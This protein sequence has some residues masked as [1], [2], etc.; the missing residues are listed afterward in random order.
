MTMNDCLIYPGSR[1]TGPRSGARG[2]LRRRGAAA[3]LVDGAVLA[4]AL[5]ACSSDAQ[6]PG[7]SATGAAGGS[8]GGT[9]GS[10]ATGGGAGGSGGATAGSNA[11][12]GGAGGSGATG[13][14]AG[15]S[16]AGAGGSGGSGGADGAVYTNP[17]IPG[18]FADPSVIRVGNDYWATATSSEWGAPFPLLHSTD[19]VNW[20]RV[21][22]VF[23]E[24]PSWAS[25]SLWAPEISEDGG[26]YQVFYT[27][28]QRG[29]PLCVAAASAEAPEGPYTDHG[30]LTCMEVG[31][32][33]GFPIRD[34]DGVRHLVW[35]E[36][37]NSVGAPTP[38]WAQELSEDGTE[39]LGAPVALFQNE[40]SWEANL[41]E[42]PYLMRHGGY[43]YAFYSGAGCCG[44]SCSYSLGVARAPGLLGP[45]EKNPANP[46]LAGN[47][48]WKCPG[49]G[50]VVDDGGGRF[51]LLYHAYSV[52]DSVYVGRQGLLDEAIFGADGWPTI[53]GGAG[54]SATAEAPIAPQAP[55]PAE[56][57]DEFDGDALDPHWQW[58]AAAPPGAALDPADGGWLTLQAAPEAP[59][60]QLG[61][62]IGRPTL[63]GDYEVTTELAVEPDVQAGL[64]A[65]GDGAS[66]VGISVGGGLAAVFRLANSTS[67][68]VA[69]TSTPG[70]AQLRM[71]VANG[72]LFRFAI[73]ADGAADWAPLGGIVDS[74]AGPDLPPWDRGVRAALF[75]NGPSG[76]SARFAS[77]RMAQPARQ[78]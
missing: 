28:R 17:V 52:E 76:A 7:G 24:L 61:A 48:V 39:L 38:L 49:H 41:V 2:P 77:F 4:L 58:P 37:G 74:E 69:E 30:P 1:D 35:K 25:G 65:Y 57:V 63:R 59:D 44:K 5:V 33:D 9:A 42:G 29:G 43:F 6:P 12:G 46:I 13:G 23:S 64:A 14:G 73:R 40:P 21:G 11:T 10:G 32:I 20:E 55:W 60:S 8:G 62:V 27:A 31:S 22:S 3:R 47:E 45:W 68:V 19:L 51:F 26:R 67:E 75:A 50:S 56:I 53:R 18:D 16:G 15:G 34:E 78:P 71:T 70:D 54:P 66:A 72:H 36:D